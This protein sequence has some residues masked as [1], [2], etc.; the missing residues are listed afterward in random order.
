MYI[1]LAVAR[2]I[3]IFYCHYYYYSYLL[4]VYINATTRATATTIATCVMYM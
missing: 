1:I 4:R 2:T 3:D